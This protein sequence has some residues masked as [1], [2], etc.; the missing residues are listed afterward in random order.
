[1]QSGNPFQ[2]PQRPHPARVQQRRQRGFGYLMALF[3]V[4]ALGLLAAAAGQVWH[5]T[6]Q[7][8]REDDLLFAGQQY[9]QALDNYFANK[10]G[11]VQQY[12]Q[13][14]EELLD[15][16]RSQVTLRHLRR[17]YPDPITGQADWVLVTAGERI[18]GLHSRSQQR[19]IKHSFEG[20]D[21]AFGTAE[22][23]DQWV[24]RAGT[25]GAAP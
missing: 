25:S 1:M 6:A 20:A 9:R 5:T 19:P 24:F 16:R 17:L 18:V 11:G 22:R 13:R 14:L 10:A 4:S 7:R 23:Y 12:P 15:D 8:L 3:A 21:A 2:R